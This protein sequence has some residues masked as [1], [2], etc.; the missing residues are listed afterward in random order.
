M[1]SHPILISYMY[2]YRTL[3]D[4]LSRVIILLIVSIFTHMLSLPSSPRCIFP[5]ARSHITSLVPRI[6][7]SRKSLN[8]GQRII[9]QYLFS[10]ASS[11]KPIILHYSI[12]A[13]PTDVPDIPNANGRQRMPPTFRHPTSSTEKNLLTGGRRGEEG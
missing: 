13:I 8:H 5:R 6:V 10:T 9:E 11:T 2:R 4:L 12:L 1:Q 3:S 7:L